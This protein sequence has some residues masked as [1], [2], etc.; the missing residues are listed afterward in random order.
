MEIDFHRILPSNTTSMLKNYLKIAFRGLWKDR[1]FTLLNLLGLSA[2]LSCALLIVLWVND[3]VTTDRFHQPHLYQVMEHRKHEK[4]IQ[5][6]SS[7]PAVLDEQLEA[8]FP[9]VVR[10]VTITPPDWFTEMTLTTGNDHIKSAGLFAGSNYFSVFS[11]PLLKGNAARVLADKNSVVI[12]EQL[13]RT[14][15]KN[16]DNAIGRTVEWK[17]DQL[18]KQAV[19]TGVFAPLS[20][21]SVQFDFV[22]HFDIFR[23]I[24]NLRDFGP[25][26]PF[27]T[28]LVLQPG[29]VEDKFNRQLSSFMTEKSQAERTIFLKPYADNYLYGQYEQGKQSGGRIWYVQLFSLI[30]IFIILMACINFMNMYTAR[31]ALRMKEM[32]IRKAIGASRGTLIL[33]Y[34]GEA[35]LITI[36]SLVVAS[37]LVALLLPQFNAITGKSLSIQFSPV[38]IFSVIGITLFTGLLAGSYPAF[39]LSGFNPVAVL[40]GRLHGNTGELWTRKGLVVFQFCMSVSFIIATLVVYKQV[41]Y[42]QSRNTGYDKDNVIYFTSEGRVSANMPSFLAALKRLPGVAN[43]SA[44]VGNL[45]GAPTAPRQYSIDGKEGEIIARPLLA[46]EGLIETL[47]IEMTAGR[48]FSKDFTTDADK[49]I[50]NEAAIEAMGIQNPVG[51]VITFNGTQREIIGITKNFHFQSLHEAVKPLFFRLDSQ[52]GTIMVRLKEG[53]EKQTVAAIAAF[54]K[55]YNPGFAFESKFLD[56]TYQA[57]YTAEKRTA[58]LS[59]WF[60]VLAVIISCLGLFGLAAFTAERR[61]KEIGIRKVMGATVNNVV[62]MMGMDL[63]KH[64]AIAI[65]LAIPLSCWLMSSWLG[66]FAYHISLGPDVFLIAGGLMVILTVAT[67]SVQT[68][69]AAIANPVKSLK[70]E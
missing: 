70:A 69:K 20:H 16:A 23:E 56:E 45:Q 44:M 48:P 2:G 47:G 17:F 28:Y 34:L 59:A 21:S 54:Y 24:M 14:L 41:G 26:G 58:S 62:I 65:V 5:T 12:S 13:A 37:V 33:Q 25:D 1:R 6:S 29:I 27:Y 52:T 4:G 42:I 11:Y 66:T 8:N 61:R 19:V 60:A 31:A 68:I 57:Q 7:M 49:L 30:A 63:M 64:I 50:F 53:Q 32:G 43:A 10:A 18:S 15:F 35:M 38:L 22:L 9:G 55:Q 51:K 39:Y 67:I 36:L 3:E 40:K 46:Q